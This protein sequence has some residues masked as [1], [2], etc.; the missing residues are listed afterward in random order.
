MRDLTELTLAT[1][2][3]TLGLEELAKEVDAINQAQA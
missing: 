3:S 2:A 1:D